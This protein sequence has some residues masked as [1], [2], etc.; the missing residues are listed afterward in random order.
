MSLD[1]SAAGLTADRS[2]TVTRYREAVE[3][4][5]VEGLLATLAQDADL[6]SPISDRALLRGRAAIRD[7][8]VPVY[9][10]LEDARVL[11]EVASADG[12]LHVLYLQTH[13]R[14]GQPLE[15]SVWLH[16]DEQGLVDE[17]TLFIRPLSA[18]TALMAS[19]G[20]PL[21]ARH[22]R[23]RALIVTAVTR[24][25]A[26]LTRHGDPLALRLTGTPRR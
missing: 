11:D 14:G 22:G 16:L 19:I 1:A 4:L 20:P 24:P 6:H 21:A 17:L 18:L 9:E 5:D 7:V 23:L 26:A 3:R 2:A 10:N 25:L 8:L 13:L 12:R 15:E